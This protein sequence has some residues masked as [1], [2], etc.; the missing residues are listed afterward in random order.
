MSG[1]PPRPCLGTR[2]RGVVAIAVGLLVTL[3][4]VAPAAEADRALYA[5]ICMAVPCAGTFGQLQLFRDK[6]GHLARILARGD[7]RVCSHP[8]AVYFNAKGTALESVDDWLRIDKE[9]VRAA[10]EFHAR[11]TA[12]LKRAEVV[13][14][15]DVCKTP[16]RPD[17]SDTKCLPP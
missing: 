12:G 3:N 1:S 8:P 15:L 11:M 2:R 10:E 13:A 14:C 5:R 4:A 17:P 6:R 7:F 9:T 16:S